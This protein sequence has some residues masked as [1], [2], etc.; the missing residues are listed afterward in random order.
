ML[1]PCCLRVAHLGWWQL[2][3][4][5]TDW[6]THHRHH[7]P[8]QHQLLQRWS[9]SRYWHPACCH[10]QQKRAVALLHRCCCHLL[11]LLQVLQVVVGVVA[12]LL[13]L[14]GE[15]LL[16]GH[17]L[18]LLQPHPYPLLQVQ[19]VEVEGAVAGAQPLLPVLPHCQQLLPPDCRW[20]AAAA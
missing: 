18:P 2:S 16:S 7:H 5:E 19:V 6:V 12:A 3:P 8:Q 4:P 14:L 13:L 17:L 10:L 20:V 1:L 11:L 15:L 9:Q